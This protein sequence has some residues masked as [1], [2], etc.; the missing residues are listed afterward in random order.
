MILH[1]LFKNKII[2]F[3]SPYTS[4]SN[5]R[6]KGRVISVSRKE[7]T[8]CSLADGIFYIFPKKNITFL[9][10]GVNLLWRIINLRLRIS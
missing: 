3:N 8:V 2:I 9:N 10:K 5:F 1:S 4:I 6:E 7:V